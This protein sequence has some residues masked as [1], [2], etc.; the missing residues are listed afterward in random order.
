MLTLYI[1]DYKT[2]TGTL[3]GDTKGIE[4]SLAIVHRLGVGKFGLLDFA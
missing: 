3:N 1:M 2:H 4:R